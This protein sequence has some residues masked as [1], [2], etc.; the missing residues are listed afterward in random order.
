MEIE[1]I[2]TWADLFAWA[3]WNNLRL[4]FNNRDWAN[5]PLVDVRAYKGGSPI[6]NTITGMSLDNPQEIAVKLYH[7]INQTELVKAITKGLADGA[8][9]RF[10]ENNDWAKKTYHF[11][12]RIP[13]DD[14][15]MFVV[16]DSDKGKAEYR[17]C[18]P[19]EMLQM[20]KEISENDLTYWEQL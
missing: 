17:T 20:M 6:A 11:V 14:I 16:Y 7:I 9:Y 19:S 10:V 1:K 5:A 13:M 18:L 2:T 8:A 15:C 4:S 12:Q 3:T